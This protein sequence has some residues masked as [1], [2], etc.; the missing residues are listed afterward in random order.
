MRAVD[1]SHRITPEMPVYPGTPQPEFSPVSSV[2]ENGYA[3]QLL[4][5][6]SHTGTHVDL[7]AHLF[8]GG[9][10]LDG[11]GLADFCGRGVVIDIPR[12]SGGGASRSD[13]LCYSD[14]MK[15]ADF[16]LLR[17]GWDRYW[18]TERYFHGYPVL[19]PDTAAWLASFGIRGIGADTVS[20]DPPSSMQYDVHRILLQKEIV[21]IENL[22]N[23]HLL[24]EAGFRFFCLPLN[25]PGAEACPVRAIAL[26]G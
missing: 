1:L 12:Y 5:M 8:S 7:P 14:R 6:S 24:P 23:L 16:V 9:K 21:L 13:L 15:G 2:Q 20:F 26:L 17:S 3:E 25:I 11:F 4:T 22:T 19:Q 10:T 18:G